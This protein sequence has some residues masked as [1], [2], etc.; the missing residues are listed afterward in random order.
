MPETFTLSDAALSLL[1]RRLSGERV[2]VTS[3]SAAAYRELAGA[4][5]VEAV[6]TPRGRD[7][8]YR[9]TPAAMSQKDVLSATSRA[10]SL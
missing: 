8:A 2:E 5:F 4:G 7:S 3:E 6:H 10:A 1:R 9:L